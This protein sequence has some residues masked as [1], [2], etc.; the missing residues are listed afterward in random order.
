MKQILCIDIG[1]TRIK[2]AVLPSSPNLEQIKN[3]SAKVIRTLGWLNGSLPELLNPPHWAG[4]A[5]FY[6]DQGLQYD[7]VAVSVPGPVSGAGVFGRA[8]LVNGPARVPERL[9]DAFTSLA[10]CE[11]TLVKDAD[12]WMMGFL[13]YRELLG[14][15][16][17]FPALIIALGTG[18]GVSLA[19]SAN[20]VRSIEVNEIPPGAWRQL[21]DAAQRNLK[22]SWEVH[23][24]I[25]HSF[26]EWV[27]KDRK[28]WD[29]LQIR[30][31]FTDRVKAALADMLPWMEHRLD[32]AV[33]TIVLAGGNAD[34]VSVREL[35]GLGRTVVSLTDSLTSLKPDLI[36]VL[37]VEASSR[38]PAPVPL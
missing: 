31:Q 8:D 5:R 16:T 35:S 9:K 18:A 32:R 30:K 14:M 12:A 10:C 7:A 2:S 19:S 20:L 38:R 26:F 27:E 36:T 15:E 29:Y 4:L 22:E 17:A 28:A 11:V 34:Y 25:G 21:R 3:A 24:M 37:G 6:G 23:G 13:S 1:G 33:R